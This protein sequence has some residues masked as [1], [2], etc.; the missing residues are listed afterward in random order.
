MVLRRRVGTLMVVAT[1]IVAAACGQ[2][3]GVGGGVALTGDGLTAAPAAVAPA[4]TPAETAPAGSGEAAAVPVDPTVTVT[5]IP[6]PL[7][8]ISA[9]AAP[10][11]A[12]GAS[13]RPTP[14]AGPAPVTP[15]PASAG[16][17]PPA[18]GSRPAT[19]SPAPTGGPQPAP[20]AQPAGP[21]PAP[22]PAPAGP[23]DRTGVTD[24][25]IKVGVHAPITGA[26]PFPQN[27]FDKGKDVYWKFLAT[28]GGVHGR[29]VE[30]ILLDDQYNPS[31]AV[32]VCRELVEQKKVMLLTGYGTEQVP[33]CAEY[34]ASAG[35]PYLAAGSNE[36]L[37]GLRTYF[38][39]SHSFKQQAPLIAAMV[40]KQLRMTKLAIVVMDTPL[41]NE[42]L[43]SITA[44]ANEQGLQIVRT[45]RISKN[46]SDSE[47][48]A[49]ANQ[50]KASGAEAVY[51]TP[52]PVNFIKLATNA[53]AQAYNPTWV[54]PF[55]NGLNLVAQAGCPSIEGAR[56]MSPWP[57][58]D[59]IDRLD[60]DFRPAYN[61][62]A[63]GQPDDLGLA[64]WG[65]NKVFH[66]MFEAVGRDLSR[67]SLMAMLTGGTE[68]TTNIFP[69][70]KYGPNNRLGATSSHVLIADCG[71]RE[72]K[73]HGAFVEAY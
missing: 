21:A 72:Y 68:I 69:K 4:P 24:T 56:F 45:S 27:S 3:D 17:A 64:L 54:G 22:A 25:L 55:G 2:K 44:A 29:N 19:G 62:Y 34:A 13:G 6:D 47:L 31:K 49:E 38:A 57:G 61:K 7:A 26:A 66:K 10:A 59:A 12:P 28:R 16:A 18:G 65:N 15:A 63:G 5:P 41:M 52:P 40:K 67:Q 51:I 23:V 53:R 71:A 20:A 48:L 50:L 39:I 9:P 11:P 1:V 8:T 37:A 46:A 58:L 43:A 35:V 32:Q 60:P 42:A 70:L 33:V 36:D 30:V 73:T 14:D